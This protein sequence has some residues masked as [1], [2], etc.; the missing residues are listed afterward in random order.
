[1]YSLMLG[2]RV[3][4]DWERDWKGCV[5]GGGGGMGMLKECI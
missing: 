1:M 2:V 5:V 4:P 3:N